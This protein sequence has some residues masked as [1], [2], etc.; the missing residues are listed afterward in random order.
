MC[1][2]VSPVSCHRPNPKPTQ[3]ALCGAYLP[4]PI[5]LGLYATVIHITTLLVDH[6]GGDEWLTHWGC[7]NKLNKK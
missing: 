4:N 6:N 5:L 7:P 1:F 3:A 2:E